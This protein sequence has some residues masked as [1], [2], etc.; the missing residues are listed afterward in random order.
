MGSLL[1]LHPERPFICSD[2]CPTRS[3]LDHHSVL[4]IGDRV[5][6]SDIEHIVEGAIPLYP[7]AAFFVTSCLGGADSRGVGSSAGRWVG[8]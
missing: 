2:M 4:L 7:K 5:A 1:A 8:I 6:A 3:V